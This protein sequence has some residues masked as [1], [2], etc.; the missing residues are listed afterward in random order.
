ML[1][2]RDITE[3]RRLDQVRRDFVANASHELKTPGGLDPGRGRDDPD[4][5]RPRTPR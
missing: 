3:T 4:G 5:G 2:I 1:V